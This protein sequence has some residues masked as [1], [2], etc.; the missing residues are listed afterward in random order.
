MDRMKALQ[1]LD[2]GDIV[3]PFGEARLARSCACR[4]H[5]IWSA[6]AK[7]EHVM[8]YDRK[9]TR[10]RAFLVRISNDF[11]RFRAETNGK[12]IK[13]LLTARSEATPFKEQGSLVVKSAIGTNGDS[14]WADRLPGVSAIPEVPVRRRELFARAIGAALGW[15]G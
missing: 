7:G 14:A 12:I 15:R 9:G 8:V 2:C 13:R 5:K 11:L 3:G 6:E 1:C 4:R 10:D